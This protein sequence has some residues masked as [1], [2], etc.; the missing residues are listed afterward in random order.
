MKNRYLKQ[1]PVLCDESDQDLEADAS[2]TATP[3]ILSSGAATPEPFGLDFKTHAVDHAVRGVV[4]SL[5]QEL[6]SKLRELSSQVRETQLSST[7]DELDRLDHQIKDQENATKAEEDDVEDASFA[8]EVDLTVRMDETE[9]ACHPITAERLEEDELTSKLKELTSQV[10]ET[11]LSSTEDELDRLDHPTRNQKHETKTQEGDGII[12][13][14]TFDIEVDSTERMNE[15]EAAY[16]PTGT[17]MLKEDELTSKLK[18]LTR[19]V[20]ESQLSSTEDELDRFE[21]QIEL[22]VTNQPIRTEM[23]ESDDNTTDNQDKLIQCQEKPQSHVEKMVEKAEEERSEKRPGDMVPE[24]DISERNVVNEMSNDITT[25]SKKQEVPMT[26]AREEIARERTEKTEERSSAEGEQSGAE[27]IETVNE[28]NK[29]REASSSEL[30]ISRLLTE[31]GEAEFDR[32]ID[33]V[34]K[35]LDNMEEELE[36][37]C[38]EE[39]FLEGNK[40]EKREIMED[41][42]EKVTRGVGHEMKDGM[43]FEKSLVSG[44]SNEVQEKE[45]KEIKEVVAIENSTEDKEGMTVVESSKERFEL[46]DANSQ[47]D[48]SDSEIREQQRGP[49]SQSSVWNSAPSGQEEY[50]SPEEIC[51]VTTTLN[52]SARTLATAYFFLITFFSLSSFSFC[53]TRI[54]TYWTWGQTYVLSPIYYDR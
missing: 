4:G 21:D 1:D 51:K 33:I 47:G 27:N 41:E 2:D 50:L 43:E 39:I 38:G 17:E 45:M 34:A 23:L 32:I 36:A 13:N 25:D 18:K 14:T 12:K 16:E 44:R 29:Q 10:S 7:E 3:D 19:Q 52:A 30:S 49:V 15:T 6:T 24:K 40:A 5:D 11:Q 31:D 22:D 53:L 37:Y 46:K 9:A 26:D 8:I 54:Y 48:A 28:T 35:A 42:E 20:S